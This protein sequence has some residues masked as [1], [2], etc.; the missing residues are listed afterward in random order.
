MPVPTSYK[1]EIRKGKIT[2][3]KQI[4]T[5]FLVPAKCGRKERESA[6]GEEDRRESS[7]THAYEIPFLDFGLEQ[8]PHPFL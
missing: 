5:Y 2:R 8:E 6:R 7:Q 3:R 1:A 4:N